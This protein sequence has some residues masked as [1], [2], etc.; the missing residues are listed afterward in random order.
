MTNE[1]LQASVAEGFSLPVF[2]KV[3]AYCNTP[4][5]GLS[6]VAPSNLF[7]GDASVSGGTV[8]YTFLKYRASN[9]HFGV[10]VNQKRGIFIRVG[11]VLN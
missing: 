9:I 10:D 8:P 11:G 5:R 6:R 7:E 1:N 3:G 4:L 2:L